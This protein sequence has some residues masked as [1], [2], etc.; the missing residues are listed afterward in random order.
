M[1]PAGNQPWRLK[2][3]PFFGLLFSGSSR[4]KTADALAAD[5][6]SQPFH[7]QGRKTLHAFSNQSLRKRSISSVFT[8]SL[9]T[10]TFF[11]YL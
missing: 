11:E 2:T 8:L 5:G 6:A 3:I 9:L 10:D 7:K 1:P 4:D